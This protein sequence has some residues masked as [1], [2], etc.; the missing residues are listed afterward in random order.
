LVATALQVPGNGFGQLSAITSAEPVATADVLGGG[1]LPEPL[2]GQVFT[3]APADV[4]GCSQELPS[5]LQFRRDRGFLAIAVKS[6][7]EGF[8]MGSV[9]RFSHGA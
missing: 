3:S 7:S 2:T 4:L 6:P 9:E 1:Q 8:P 5:R